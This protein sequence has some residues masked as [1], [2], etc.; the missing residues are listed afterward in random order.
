MR[1]FLRR[2]DVECVVGLGVPTDP[3][4]TTS[5]VGRSKTERKR[6]GEKDRNDNNVV[7]RTGGTGIGI[8]HS[9]ALVV[10]ASSSLRGCE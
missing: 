3:I 9:K 6:K 8:N 10:R 4:C 7:V 5:S 1:F 2:H